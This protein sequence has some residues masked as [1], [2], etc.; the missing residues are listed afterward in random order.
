MSSHPSGC[1][2]REREAVELGEVPGIGER[3]G[4]VGV[5]HERQPREAGPD[6]RDQGHVAAG[7][8]LDLHAPVPGRH[9]GLDLVE[10]R[11]LVLL[12]AHRDAGRDLPPAA[13]EE[14]PQRHALAARPQLPDRHLERGLRHLVPA[15]AGEGGKHVARVADLERESQG[16]E[17]LAQDVERGDV[18]LREVEGVDV[19]HALGVAVTPPAETETSRNCLTAARP[20]EVSRGSAAAA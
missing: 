9:L 6:R 17:E 13:A 1:D 10:E 2:H 18:G 14:L 8:D 7:L 15:H 19:S 16:S 20:K 12:Q 3:V 11:R 5:H 4:A